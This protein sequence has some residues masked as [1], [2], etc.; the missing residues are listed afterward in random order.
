MNVHKQQNG[1]KP[2]KESKPK[3]A[4]NIYKLNQKKKFVANIITNGTCNNISFILNNVRKFNNKNNY[5]L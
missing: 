2:M 3:V 1:I 5:K 4:I